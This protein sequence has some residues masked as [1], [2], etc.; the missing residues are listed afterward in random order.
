[1]K[2]VWTLKG[3]VSRIVPSLAVIE[4]NRMKNRRENRSKSHPNCSSVWDFVQSHQN[5]SIAPERK[6]DF[7]R[8]FQS[9]VKRCVTVLTPRQQ[10]NR[11]ISKYLQESDENY[12]SVTILRDKGPNRYKRKIKDKIFTKK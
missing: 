2:F 3:R 12:Q 7:V 1:V 8:M 10:Q 11:H 6:R 5:C 9:H 4:P